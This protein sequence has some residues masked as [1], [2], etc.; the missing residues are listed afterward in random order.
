MHFL[1]LNYGITVQGNNM[2]ENCNDNKS[3]FIMFH[4]GRKIDKWQCKNYISVEKREEKGF[5]LHI[6]NLK[7]EKTLSLIC[8]VDM[9]ITQSPGER[10]PRG[11]KTSFYDNLKRKNRSSTRLY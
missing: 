8:P 1:K 6:G 5:D 11:K 4:D 9:I 2:K 7:K 10:A 3:T